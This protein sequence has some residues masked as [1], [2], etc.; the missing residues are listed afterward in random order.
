LKNSITR[1]T[2]DTALQRLGIGLTISSVSSSATSAVIAFGRRHGLS[3]ISTHSTLTGGSGHTSGTFYNVKLYNEVGLTNWDGATAKVVVSAGGAVVSSEIIS[4]GSGYANGETLYFDTAEIGGSANAFIT[5]T[6]AG[7]STNIGDV[8]QF[9]GIGTTSDGYYRINS[10][11]SA[12]TISI[13]KT[14]GDP[15]ILA[16][17]YGIVIGPS[18]QVTGST[19]DSTTGI[20]SFTT[21]SSHGLLV[22]NKFKIINSNNTNLG[23]YIVSEKIGV[24]EFNAIT[25]SGITTNALYVLP[26]GLSSNEASTDVSNE[27]FGARNLTFFDSQTFTLTTNLT[28][29][30]TINISSSG[31][32]TAQ[33]LP[34][35]SYIQI[36][37]E[38]MRIVSSNN[39][40][41]TNSSTAIEVN[42]HTRIC[43]A[44]FSVCGCNCNLSSSTTLSCI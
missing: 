11:G 29:G 6:T 25:N 7:I 14:S 34:L 17:Q 40:K 31:I 21:S 12:T 38:I 33:R 16:N 35:G 42:F 3:G 23:N 27:N 30:T 37:N 44:C 19:Y 28:T 26:H 4:G 10:V 22:G 43:S 32:G 1:E 2:V 15:V 39:T 8:I 20:T 36:D 24:T 41:L 9:T 18:A 13:A 5:I